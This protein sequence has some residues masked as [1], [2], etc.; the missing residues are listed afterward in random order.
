MDRRSQPYRER[1][2]EP[3]ARE[4]DP[5]YWT[6]QDRERD[7]GEQSEEHR[8]ANKPDLFANVTRLT[9]RTT[10]HLVGS[11]ISTV[12]TLEYN[13][14]AEDWIPYRTDLDRIFAGHGTRLGEAYELSGYLRTG[15]LFAINGRV[16]VV[17]KNGHSF[18]FSGPGIHRL[19]TAEFN[20][21]K[22]LNVV[23]T[24]VFEQTFDETVA[25]FLG[26]SPR[27]RIEFIRR[28]AQSARRSQ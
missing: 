26:D 3:P 23:S 10:R 9:M 27:E 13:T 18:P 24:A 14:V 17:Q 19:S 20:V 11:V 6:V 21:W 15:A 7:D 4:G 2:G 5:G 25:E 12:K 22:R 16:Y 1:Y 28:L 8:R